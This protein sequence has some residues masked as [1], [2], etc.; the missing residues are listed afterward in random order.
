MTDTEREKAI[1]GCPTRTGDVIV[2][3]GERRRVASA[4]VQRRPRGDGKGDFGFVLVFTEE[5]A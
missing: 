2:V 1:V 3:D 5:G 4:E